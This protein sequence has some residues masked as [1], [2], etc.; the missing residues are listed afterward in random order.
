MV[1]GNYMSTSVD[2]DFRSDGTRNGGVVRDVDDGQKCHE[3]VPKTLEPPD[4]CPWMVD[5]LCA[6]LRAAED[7]VGS[8]FDG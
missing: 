4:G 6:R 5:P 3:I 7:V 1:D 2:F 8:A